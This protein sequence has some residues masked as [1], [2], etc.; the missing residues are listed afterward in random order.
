MTSAYH[1]DFKHIII[2]LQK[3]CDGINPED[4]KWKDLD[5]TLVGLRRSHNIQVKVRC[6]EEVVDQGV[7]YLFPEMLKTGHLEFSLLKLAVS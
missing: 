7:Q 1:L 4:L 6:D 2:Y 5:N 3:F